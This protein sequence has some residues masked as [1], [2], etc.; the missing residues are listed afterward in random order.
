MR[1]HE[2]SEGLFIG[3]E[4]E[5]HSDDES[6]MAMLVEE[7]GEEGYY[8]DAED[9]PGSSYVCIGEHHLNRI[10]VTKLIAILRYWLSNKKLPISS[11][12]L[13]SVIRA[14]LLS[15]IRERLGSGIIEEVEE[16]L[17]VI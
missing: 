13:D 5:K 1:V 12:E 10:D 2:N 14:E 6:E 16:L 4:H 15:G 9:Y 11:E 3:I 7:S 17:S 8:D